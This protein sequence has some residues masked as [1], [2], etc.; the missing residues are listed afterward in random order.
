MVSDNLLTFAA[1]NYGFDKSTLHFISDSTNQVYMYKKDEKGYILRFSQRSAGH[2]HK[3]K[4]EMDWL[5]YLAK[6]DIGVSLP[7]KAGGGELAVSTQDGGENYIVTSFEM[8]SGTFWNKD[9]P[10]KWNEKIFYNW[11]KVMGDMHRL[12]K[13]YK[14]AK[15]MDVREA[16]TG[17]D[18]LADTIK[19]CPSLNK[20][21]EELIDEMMT[22]PKDKDSYGLIHCDIHPWNFYID[23]GKINVFDFDDSLYGWFALDMGIALY[24]G[25]WWGRK[26][27]AGNDFTDK[28]IE[29]FIKGYLSANYLSGFW[30]SRIPM[31]MKFRQICKFSWFYDPENADDH[32]RERIYNIENDMLF[33]GIS[34]KS[35]YGIIENT[36]N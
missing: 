5:Y 35:L 23:G 20:I 10:N 6:N 8:V 4:A 22:L 34:A 14:P 9:D 24:H 3:I 16:F 33:T 31:F 18:A 15:S 26:D 36:K 11:G 28:I 19:L 29:N 27:D 2:I 7:L 25:L 30:L 1:E 17:R 12:T 21:A 32:Q 13:D